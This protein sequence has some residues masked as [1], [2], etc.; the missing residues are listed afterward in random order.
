MI[1]GIDVSHWQKEIDW[2]L[3]KK[4]GIRFAFFKA[5]EFP[6]K[7][8]KLFTDPDMIR[9][10][11]GCIKNR[12][13]AGPYHFY[14]THIPA[15]TQAFAFLDTIQK[16]SFNLCP[17]LDLEVSTIYGSSL[18]DDV[19]I[20]CE[21]VQESLGVMPIIYTSG[22][23]WRSYMNCGKSSHVER[24]A[25]YPL[26]LAQWG[27]TMP[28]PLFPFTGPAFWQYS[29]SGRIPGINAN[30]DLDWF[31]G[32]ELELLPYLYLNSPE[33]HKPKTSERLDS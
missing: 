1:P 15:L 8:T 19:E 7:S 18:C 9:N 22:G 12:I 17:V 33:L 14:R 27:F 16:L 11:D 10:A 2:K 4:S 13:H 32:G 28:K 26:W 29:Q 31:L 23:F 25:G 21:A 24:F 3:V 6:P 20:F 5:T 30:V